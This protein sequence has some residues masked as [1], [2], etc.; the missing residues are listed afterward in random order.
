MS[1]RATTKHDIQRDEE[2][3]TRQ[4]FAVVNQ[5]FVTGS[6]YLLFTGVDPG[7]GQV[8][9]FISGSGVTNGDA[10][11]HTGT[12]AS[13]FYTSLL[14]RPAAETNANA[15]YRTDSPG[16]ASAWAGTISGTPAGAIISYTNVSG[17]A[18]TLVPTSSSQLAKVRLYNIT[19]G[20]YGLISTA[21]STPTAKITLTANAPAGWANG[22]RITVASSQV[23]GAPIPYVDL[24][25]TSGILGRLY[26]FI[27]MNI[28]SATPGDNS[29]LHPFES[30]ATSKQKTAQ[31]LVANL[32]GLQ[33]SLLLK[34]VNNVLSLGWTGT[35]TVVLLTEDGYLE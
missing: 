24:E 25:F 28:I 7:T 16:G 17:T 14:Q 9:L 8:T 1:I 5:V 31:A 4:G 23:F 15:I 35:P 20:D 6:M 11:N 22:D 32:N 27:T 33:P 34:I 10:H 29:R 3:S 26:V 2:N 13:I 21:S 12:V 19:R 30:F 18:G